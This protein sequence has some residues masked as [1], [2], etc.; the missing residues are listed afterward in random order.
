MIYKLIGN[1]TIEIES[2]KQFAIGLKW[3]EPVLAG[4]QFASKV[5]LSQKLT[6]AKIDAG[7]EFTTTNKVIQAAGVAQDEQKNKYSLASYV[8][9]VLSPDTLVFTRI[10]AD[11]FWVLMRNEDG[12][13][14]TTS[15]KIMDSA[16]LEQYIRERL[17]LS[18]SENELRIINIGID[19]QSDDLSL[20][21]KIEYKP[22]LIDFE[23][24]ELLKKSLI[25]SLN[26]NFNQKLI[27]GVGLLFAGIVGAGYYYITTELPE[28]EQ[29]QN[30]YYS[31]SFNSKY[32]S[33][34]RDY[35][36]IMNANRTGAM[37]KELFVREA[38][39]QYNEFILSYPEDSLKP[40]RVLQSIKENL[41]RYSDGWFKSKIAYTDGKFYVSYERLGVWPSS[42][43]FLTLDKSLTS[44]SIEGGVEVRPLRILN[45]GNM[46]LYEYY[47]P[48]EYSDA[49]LQFTQEERR[50]LDQKSEIVAKISEEKRQLDAIKNSI[51]ETQNSVYNLNLLDKKDPLIAQ[52]IIS[53]ITQEVKKSKEPIKAIKDMVSQ[54]EEIGE[55]PVP[56]HN[57]TL[58]KENGIED[59]IYPMMQ[60]MPF[61]ERGQ[62][63]EDDGFPQGIEDRF[64]GDKT[65]I[66]KNIVKVK[67]NLPLT[68]INRAKT[69]LS[70][71]YVFLSDVIVALPLE[72]KEEITFNIFTHELNRDYAFLNK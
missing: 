36:A 47:L 41:P 20:M 18:V 8:A 56:T 55:V 52:N 45:D 53:S 70:K 7:V 29:I 24:K 68:E 14:E 65:Y 40:F 21:D 28:I 60:R 2:G 22:D 69:L 33:V 32:S 46:R 51:L 15:D 34:N 54:Y 35:N 13:I 50:V 30:G 43:D 37:N 4:N 39:K 9:H 19:Y 72:G 1:N 6:E 66:S 49:Y 61:L 71:D 38:Q 25:G 26:T 62:P 31:G 57:E 17:R 16:D 5:R 27:A 44:I 63:Q 3:L 12:S 59:L 58:L 11:T 67:F 64:F 48:K 42:A 23:D 10:E